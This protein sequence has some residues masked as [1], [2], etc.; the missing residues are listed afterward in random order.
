MFALSNFRRIDHTYQNLTHAQESEKEV[1]PSC[2][3]QQ[4]G[5]LKA[6]V[7]FKATTFINMSGKLLLEKYFVCF[8]TYKYGKY[9]IRSMFT[10]CDEYEN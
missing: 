5:S 1:M 4:W 6:P 3:E 7:E 8:C 9:F 2:I 10:V